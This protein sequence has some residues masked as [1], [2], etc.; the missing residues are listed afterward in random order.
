M[1]INERSRL[2][3][4][5]IWADMQA[6]FK[7]SD[8]R[9][10]P[11]FEP[12]NPNSA[13]TLPDGTV[14]KCKIANISLTGAAIVSNLRPPLNSTIILGQIH[15]EIRRH[16]DFGFSVEFRTIQNPA[17]LEAFAAPPP[18]VAQ[19]DLLILRNEDART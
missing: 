1:S 12:A 11:R 8:L 19:G 10:F 2:A 9:R 3:S 14:L 17:S 7:G 13:I 6:G 15:S 16:M 5:I 4:R 18:S